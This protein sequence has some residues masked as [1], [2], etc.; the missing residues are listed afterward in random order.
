[1][2]GG[3]RRLA[4]HLERAGAIITCRDFT[5][6]V[7]VGLDFNLREDV[8]ASAYGHVG[9][10]GGCSLDADTGKADTDATL[11]WLKI[12]WSSTALSWAES[13]LKL[14]I[15]IANSSITFLI[16]NLVLVYVNIMLMIANIIKISL[17]TAVYDKKMRNSRDFVT[18]YCA[19]A[20]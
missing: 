8:Y 18:F 6:E 17:P 3:E 15:A 1:M 11:R 10:D 16:V 4:F 19:S 7:E 14:I 5:V 9:S 20:L 13:W 12:P 2:A